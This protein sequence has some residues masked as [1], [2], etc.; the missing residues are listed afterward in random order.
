MTKNDTQ[1]LPFPSDNDDDDDAPP[2]SRDVSSVGC[3]SPSSTSPSLSISEFK[4]LMT[5][6]PFAFAFSL[7][8]SEPVPHLTPGLSVSEK[9]VFK[10]FMGDSSGVSGPRTAEAFAFTTFQSE[11][12]FPKLNIILGGEKG[13]TV[14]MLRRRGVGR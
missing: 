6:P 14:Q 3:A 12:D 2:P 5:L 13:G 10:V 1:S 9:V 11:P 8:P 4:F 7:A